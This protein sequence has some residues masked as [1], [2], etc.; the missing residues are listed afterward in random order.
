MVSQYNH[1]PHAI[2]LASGLSKR[3]FGNKLEA[4]YNLGSPSL[5]ELTIQNISSFSFESIIFVTKSH[6]ELKREYKNLKF[7]LNKRPEL[8]IGESLRLG[9]EVLPESAIDLAIFLGDMPFIPMDE[10]EY[11]Y[12]EFLRRDLD[13]IRPA[14]LP[15]IGHPVLARASTLKSISM[16]TEG[17]IDI[18]K[19]FTDERYRSFF[20]ESLNPGSYFD[21]DNR[22]IS[23]AEKFASN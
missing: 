11:M 1:R 23:W 18:K 20:Y 19:S 16:E 17:R 6:I 2:V 3:Y 21:V 13:F 5:Q 8:G 10:F 14:V 22:F 12:D 15:E 7:V 9:I 4:K